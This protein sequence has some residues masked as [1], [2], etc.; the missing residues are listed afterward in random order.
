MIQGKDRVVKSS[1][2]VTFTSANQ[3]EYPILFSGDQWHV[4]DKDGDL[5]YIYDNWKNTNTK[6]TGAL[7]TQKEINDL[8][9]VYARTLEESVINLEGK[10][11]DIQKSTSSVYRYRGT[12][13]TASDLDKIKDSAPGDV[14]NVADTGMNYA[15][16]YESDKKI[17]LYDG[18]TLVGVDLYNI[19]KNLAD[20]QTYFPI[21]LNVNGKKVLY[22][23]VG[24]RASDSY[25]YY[26]ILVDN[27][28]GSG[29]SST[30]DFINL[31]SW[32]S[33]KEC[34]TE[35]SKTVVFEFLTNDSHWDA[36][37]ATVDT[38]LYW[39]D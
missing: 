12:V 28:G 39:T 14:Y 23:L 27:A 19:I 17:H 33:T 29:A 1:F 31:S 25:L 26:A 3:A 21:E 38:T 22:H 13:A 24:E 36:L 32:D 35:T 8:L 16:V 34:Y 18:T 2:G 7:F 9:A 37:G 6:G 4:V 5:C 15:F 30:D 20:A 10:V 11:D